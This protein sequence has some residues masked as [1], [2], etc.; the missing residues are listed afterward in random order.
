MGKPLRVGD[1]LGRVSFHHG[2]VSHSTNLSTCSAT[3]YSQTRQSHRLSSTRAATSYNE[4]CYGDWTRVSPAPPFENCRTPGL[5]SFGARRVGFV[6][7]A[8]GW[9]RSARGD[10]IPLK[11]AATPPEPFEIVRHERNLRLRGSSDL[12]RNL[13]AQCPTIYI[14]ERNAGNVLPLSVTVREGTTFSVRWVPDRN[15]CVSVKGRTRSRTARRGGDR[16]V[17]HGRESRVVVCQCPADREGRRFRARPGRVDG[18]RKSRP[19]CSVRS[20]RRARACRVGGGRA[21]AWRI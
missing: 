17:F 15:S 11:V 2:G 5:G 9:V 18:T 1:N 10:W 16:G 21:D 8:A 7:R 4:T 20:D 14:I 13:V 12:P 3:D 6:R 19:S